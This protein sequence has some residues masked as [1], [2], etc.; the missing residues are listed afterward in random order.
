MAEGLDLS[1]RRALVIGSSAGIGFAL[2]K[3][4]SEDGTNSGSGSVFHETET[5]FGRADCGGADFILV[6]DA[7]DMY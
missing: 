6:Y 2:S 7:P 1:G 5:L 3:G 4:L